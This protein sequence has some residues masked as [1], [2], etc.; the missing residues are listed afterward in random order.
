MRINDYLFHWDLKVPK[1]YESHRTIRVPQYIVDMIKKL[2]RTSGFVIDLNP[3]QLSE[4]F[5]IALR[6]SELPHFRFHDLRHYAASAM[7]ANGVPERYIEAIGGWKPGS[8]VLKR[9]YENVLDTE[10]ERIEKSMSEKHR[11]EV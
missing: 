8:N 1:T 7:H 5:A 2:D 3:D 10:L 9:V 4:R 6:K 11:F